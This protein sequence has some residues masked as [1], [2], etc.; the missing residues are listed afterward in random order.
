MPLSI[1]RYF[2]DYFPKSKKCATCTESSLARAQIASTILFTI[3]LQATKSWMDFKC[4]PL[5]CVHLQTIE[6]ALW[7]LSLSATTVW[8]G[9][10]SLRKMYDC[11]VSCVKLCQRSRS[12]VMWP[13]DCVLALD[14]EN[15]YEKHAKKCWQHYANKNR[16]LQCFRNYV[17]IQNNAET[18]NKSWQVIKQT[19]RKIVQ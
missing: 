14:I 18:N 2:T 3:T 12:T 17:N 4:W 10:A 15:I 7:W 11:N 5:I 16:K 13:N 6:K 9:S 19:L 8:S 1:L